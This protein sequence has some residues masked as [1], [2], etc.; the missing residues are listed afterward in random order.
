MIVLPGPRP[1]RARREKVS[2]PWPARSSRRRSAAGSCRNTSGPDGGDS[3]CTSRIRK[4]HVTEKMEVL[5]PW[6]PWFGRQVYVHA[7]VER[8]DAHSFS[9]A[10]DSQQTVR[11]LGVPAWMFDRAACMR[12]RRAA[13]P[14]VELAALVRLQTLLAETIERTAS[15]STVVGARHSFANR[16]DADATPEPSI[17]NRPT[18]SVPRSL[19]R[20]ARLALPAGRSAG[21]SDASHRADAEP[22]AARQSARPRGRRAG[23]DE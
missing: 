16:G 1:A 18:G 21:E 14:Q 7:I 19:S 10:I 12:T 11:C 3:R 2:S 23:D 5:Y 15:A 20:S 17:T 8:S 4:T 9:C 22:A 13:T 6:H